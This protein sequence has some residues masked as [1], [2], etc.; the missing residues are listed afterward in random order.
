MHAQIQVQKL[1]VPIIR[2]RSVRVSVAD[3]KQPHA[4]IGEQ[5]YPPTPQFGFPFPMR[6]VDGQDKETHKHLSPTSTFFINNV[7]DLLYSP[8]PIAH[9][10]GRMKAHP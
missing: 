2:A 4:G 9:D 8:F 10:A 5:D 7:M 6:E 3:A 1:R